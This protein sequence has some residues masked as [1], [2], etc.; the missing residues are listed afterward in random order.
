MNEKTPEI[1]EKALEQ[2]GLRYSIP[3]PLIPAY[4]VDT[5]TGGRFLASPWSLYP[6]T[7]Q[8]TAGLFKYK[9]LTSKFLLQEGF[10][11]VIT[12]FLTHEQL[13]DS[14]YMQTHAFPFVVKQNDG[15]GSVNVFMIHS[16][17]DLENCRKQV[18]DIA[19][20]CIQPLVKR[21]EYRLFIWKGDITFIYKKGYIPGDVLGRTDEVMNEDF[22]PL[23]K[24]IPQYLQDFAQE[25]YTKTSAEIIGADVFLESD[26]NVE[27]VP[28]ILE[29]NHN[30]GLAVMY[31]HG[32]EVEIVDL[33]SQI[34]SST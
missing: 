16:E 21:D 4:C 14:E 10:T 20:L 24:N 25:L 8:H 17:T 12:D 7:K 19:Q 5:S 11:S 34:Y 27:Q 22:T 32:Y 3:Q 6:Q 18:R 31:S 30:P 1:I 9:E 28:L 26:I 2:A 33:L 23:L 13:D 29:L 15:S